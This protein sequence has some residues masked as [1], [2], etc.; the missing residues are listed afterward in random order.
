MTARVNAQTEQIQVF[1]LSPQ[2]ACLVSTHTGKYRQDAISAMSRFGFDSLERL[3]PR[4]MMRDLSRQSS[5]PTGESDSD[6]D[7]YAAQ[8]RRTEHTDFGRD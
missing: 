7:S 6:D 3:D 5:R 2:N 1:N 4:E 8:S